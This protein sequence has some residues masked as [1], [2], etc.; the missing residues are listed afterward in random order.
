MRAMKLSE[1][2][3][4]TITEEL[5]RSFA[6]D[7][8]GAKRCSAGYLKALRHILGNQARADS[9]GT[10]LDMNH[11]VT[12]A[13]EQTMRTLIDQFSQAGITCK[14]TRATSPQHSQIVTCYQGVFRRLMS[15]EDEYLQQERR[16]EKQAFALYMLTVTSNADIPY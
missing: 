11:R 13:T 4:A 12:F 16:R 6:T 2:Y 10:E 14:R 3:I 7:T 1:G 8:L 5:L 15:W 9:T